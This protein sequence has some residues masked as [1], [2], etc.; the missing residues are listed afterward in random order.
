[1]DSPI[2]LSDARIRDRFAHLEQLRPDVV[3]FTFTPQLAVDEQY[4][5]RIKAFIHVMSEERPDLNPFIILTKIDEI[6]VRLRGN[7]LIESAVLA[8]RIERLSAETGVPL[9][10]IF[11]TIGYISEQSNNP[12]IDRFVL[13][14]LYVSATIIAQQNNLPF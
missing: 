6:D 4:H 2:R 7:P 1:M 5:S 10:N 12:A 13:N 8:Q 3:F 9:L 11:P 14:V